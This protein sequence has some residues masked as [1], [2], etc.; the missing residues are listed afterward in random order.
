MD[1]GER[2]LFFSGHFYS[3]ECTT[4]EVCGLRERACLWAQSRGRGNRA[5][6]T[7]I[8]QGPHLGPCSTVS[9]PPPGCGLLREGNVCTP[10]VGGGC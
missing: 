3:E 7:M 6:L 2:L 8:P 10:R 9:L 5:A 1:P 4:A